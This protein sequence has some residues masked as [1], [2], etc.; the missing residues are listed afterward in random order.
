MVIN[1]QRRDYIAGALVIVIGAGASILGARYQIG[2]LTRMGPGFFPAA[3]GVILGLLGALIILTAA[4]GSPS[5]AS[6]ADPHH[7]VI[8]TPDWRGWG[9]IG[10]SVIVFILCAQYLGLLAATFL[11]VFVACWGDRTATWKA[12]AALAAGVTVFGVVLFYY[13]LKVQIPIVRGM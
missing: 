5:H 11:C 8:A 2:S 3:L 6:A 10:A 4:I 12:S 13:I 1:E 9:C 7:G